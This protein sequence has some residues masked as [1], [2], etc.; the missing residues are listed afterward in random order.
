[1]TKQWLNDPRIYVAGF[2]EASGHHL[3]RFLTMPSGS[4]VRTVCCL[5]MDPN[6]HKMTIPWLIWVKCWP[7]SF[8]LFVPISCP[9]GYDPKIAHDSLDSVL[10]LLVHCRY[11]WWNTTSKSSR[12]FLWL[13]KQLPRLF[14]GSTGHTPHFEMTAISALGFSLLTMSYLSLLSWS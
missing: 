6:L 10:L 14:V 5:C 9:K 2:Y 8:V 3:G 4:D 12:I 13:C 7:L 1:M 11:A